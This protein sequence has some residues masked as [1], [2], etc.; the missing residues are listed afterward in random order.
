MATRELLNTRTEQ[1][2]IQVRRRDGC[3]ANL[4]RTSRQNSVFRAMRRPRLRPRRRAVYLFARTAIRSPQEW[5]MHRN[6]I[7][8][9]P[10]LAVICTGLVILGLVIALSLNS[11]QLRFHR[12]QSLVRVN[13]LLGLFID[14]AST[15]TIEDVL[16]AHPEWLNAGLGNGTPLFYAC[17]DKRADIVHYL[18]V[19]GA[20]PNF[21][22]DG[23]GG[24][25]IVITVSNHDI[26]ILRDLLDR[27]ADPATTDA[28]GRSVSFLAHDEQW[29]E[30]EILLRSA[31]ARKPQ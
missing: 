12:N 25:P 7:R 6:R 21:C 10:V 14:K 27:G 11:F 26:A 8:A 16:R 31:I 13:P 22:P 2:I 9:L 28:Y 19:H 17:A 30:G 15:E 18:L 3:T 20:D 29:S 23:K 24:A 1:L 4:L 5:I